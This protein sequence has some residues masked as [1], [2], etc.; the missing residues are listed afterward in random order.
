MTRGILSTVYATPA[1]G[2]T[3]PPTCCRACADTYAGEPFVVVDERIP[4]TKAV[5]G[6]NCAHLTARHDERH[7]PARW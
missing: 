1:A 7:R 6:S 3:P 2:A 5:S 4:Q